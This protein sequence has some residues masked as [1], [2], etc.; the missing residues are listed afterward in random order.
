MKYI[1]I[2]LILLIVASI[3]IAIR[4]SISYA[5]DMNNKLNY[6]F[7]M[8]NNTSKL[9]GINN[10]P[11]S[12]KPYLLELQKN[13]PNWKFT[14]LYTNLNWQDVI[15]NENVFGKNLVPKSYSDRWKN[16]EA[17]KYNV[18]IDAGWVDSSRRAVEFAMDPRNFLN[19]VRIFQFEELSYNENTN[20][21]EGIEKVLYG[22][23]FY[24]RIVEYLDASGNNIVTTSKYSDLILSAGKNSK[25][26]TY[27]LASRIKQE[28]GPFLSHSSISGNVSGFEGLY[29]FYNIGATSSSEPMGAIKNGLMYARDGKGASQATKDKYLIP[30]NNKGKAIT[31]G[32]I[33]LGSSYI[34]LGQDTIYLQKFHVV[35]NSNR[36]LFWHQYMTNVLAPY[37]E[38][39]IIYSGYSKANMLN[40]A[41]SFIIPVYNNM[42][43]TPVE[44]P[45]ILESDFISDN[46]QVYADVS[47]TLNI[48]N[49]PSTSYERITSVDKNTI[50]TRIAKGRQA[51]E[52]WDKVKLSNGMIGY[53]FH[54]YLKE[55]T[56]KEIP[57]EK[58]NLSVDKTRIKKGE[59]IKLN[60]EV[61]PPN[62]TNRAVEYSS[63]DSSTAMVYGNG[64]ILGIKSGTVGIT[65][66]SK[67]NDVSNTIYI[68]VYTPLTDMQVNVE[69]I[70]MQEG[71]RYTLTTLITPEDASNPNIIYKIE[72]E[73][74]ALVNE[75]GIITARRQGNTKITLTTEDGNITREIPILVVPRLE[76]VAFDKS[77]RIENNEI[78]GWNLND[79]TVS[80][81]KQKITTNYTIKIYGYDGK[82]LRDNQRIGT[83]ARIRLVDENE[84][85]KMEYTVIIYGDLDSDGYVDTA[86]LYILQRHIL[87]IKKLNGIFLKAGNVRRD[88]KNPSSSDSFLIRRHILELEF[89]KQ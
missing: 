13:H 31:G 43:S 76:N 87:E 59:T 47:S 57:V 39:N 16:T 24:N 48:R 25:V 8:I 30:W 51:G 17:G 62:A 68:E 7:S 40:N 80:S 4:I 67:S 56:Q 64:Y 14:A 75:K 19:E 74:I 65:V 3:S 28:V 79:L 61:L 49:G 11:D 2:F 81:V 52:L 21:L 70:T 86:D 83:G 15:N 53:A 27:H 42:N 55:A 23:E 84:N 20:T 69:S 89:I 85:I 38:S 5:L 32:G 58:I 82:L 60:V 45:N 36:N 18:E 37:S 72:D 73:N 88:G 26:S 54:L 34:N 6:N 9:D 22:T 71:D 33:F 50:M 35:D 77:L 29:N 63:T 12:Y 41:M 10:F 46:T 66:K 44:N 1:K 78:T